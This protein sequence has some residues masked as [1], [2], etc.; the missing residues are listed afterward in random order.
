MTY[1]YTDDINLE[2]SPNR[3]FE[4]Q[5]RDMDLGWNNYRA[6]LSDQ[7]SPKN[8]HQYASFGDFSNP[9]LVDKDCK[10]LDYKE[11][12]LKNSYYNTE[13]EDNVNLNRENSSVLDKTT[14]NVINY[15]NNCRLD[16]AKSEAVKIITDSNLKSYEASTWNHANNIDDEQTDE[17]MTGLKTPS[18]KSQSFTKIKRKQKLSMLQLNLSENLSKSEAGSTQKLPT[19]LN[20][21]GSNNASNN[22]N[23]AMNLWTYTNLDPNSSSKDLNKPRTINSQVEN[24]TSCTNKRESKALL[25]QETSRRVNPE[26]S[27]WKGAKNKKRSRKRKT[28]LVAACKQEDI[29]LAQRRD[30]VNK[31]ILRALRRYYA[32]RLKEYLEVDSIPEKEAMKPVFGQVCN[33]WEVLFGKQNKDLPSLQLYMAYIISPKEIDESALWKQTELDEE[34]L[35]SYYS[36]LYKYSHSKLV[37]LFSDKY[38]G[39]IYDHFYQNAKQFVLDNEPA[40]TKNVGLYTKI[41]DDFDQYFKIEDKSGIQVT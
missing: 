14:T 15:Q 41:L 7:A 22:K 32:Q 21:P 1:N 37:S 40:M 23:E 35:I 6:L 30:V 12:N 33:F 13:D 27:K 38:I 5:I 24:I 20:N 25:K 4:K 2:G 8:Y 31:T 39:I 36:W 17:T 34:H 18:M 10:S 29:D 26:K 9:K 3:L 11:L 28:K 19:K 16:S